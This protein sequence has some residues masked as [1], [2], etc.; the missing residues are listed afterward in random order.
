MIEA[1][2]AYTE[3]HLDFEYPE[4]RTREGRF[5]IS[6]PPDA[7]IARF[8]M[9]IGGRWQEA[10][11]VERRRAEQIFEDFLHRKQDLALLSKSAG[12]TF[13]ARAF[14]IAARSTQSLIVASAQ[15]LLEANA[16]YRLPLVGL[17]QIGQASL[18]VVSSTSAAHQLT[19]ENWRPQRDFVVANPAPGG[20]L[21]LRSKTGVVA[22]VTPVPAGAPAP[23][24][25]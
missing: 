2:L 20:R 22:R 12:N 9:K 11:V 4:P 24:E 25:S 3:L 5:S 16:V 10:E 8:A 17:P 6:L 14:P 18:Q 23:I 7:G 15:P 19:R 1:P 21:G 13:S